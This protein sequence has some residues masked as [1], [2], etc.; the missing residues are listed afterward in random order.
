M[1]NISS[2][3]AKSKSDS[4]QFI[5]KLYGRKQF[6]ELNLFGDMAKDIT[7]HNSFFKSAELNAFLKLIKKFRKDLGAKDYLKRKINT[8]ITKADKELSWPLPYVKNNRLYSP[9][10]QIVWLFL[11]L[12]PEYLKDY[13]AMVESYSCVPWGLESFLN[14]TNIFLESSIEIFRMGIALATTNQFDTSSDSFKGRFPEF[15]D[16]KHF[17]VFN[18]GSFLPS[19]SLL[20]SVMST[21]SE[22]P[23]P[24]YFPNLMF[25]NRKRAK[26]VSEYCVDNVL[27][28][29]VVFYCTYH[30]RCNN[31]ILNTVL[32]EVFSP[33]DEV[34][35]IKTDQ[36]NREVEKFIFISQLAPFIFFKQIYDYQMSN[37]SNGY[38]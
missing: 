25:P 34:K 8:K 33:N 12:N 1:A 2:S 37:V 30:F 28:S 6:S 24:D 5:K 21:Y 23:E 36:V 16:E 9:F 22:D 31:K 32:S 13:S 35:R 26:N 17:F 18:T 14:P 11:R 15:T 3:S 27:K 19:A 7:D 38:K 4:D 20:K 10:S 29:L